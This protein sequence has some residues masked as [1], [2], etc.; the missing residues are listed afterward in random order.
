MRSIGLPLLPFLLAVSLGLARSAAAQGFDLVDSIVLSGR[1]R[2]IY[3]AAVVVIGRRD[4]V[5]YAKGYGHFT[6]DRRAP[7]PDPA[8][9]L[10]DLASLSKV[11]GTTPAVMLLVERGLVDLDAPVQRYLPGFVGEGKPAVTVRMLLNHTSGLPS[12]IEF[13]RLAPTRDSAITLLYAE[14]LRRGPGESA[15]YSDLN[16][17]LLGLLIEARSGTS[18]DAFVSREVFQPL[19]MT[20]S[21]YRPPAALHDRVVPTGL[22]HGRPIA[23]VVNDQNA[24]R[25]G[26]VAGHAGIFSTGTDLARFAQLWLRQGELPAGGHLVQAATMREFLTPTPTSGVRLLGWESPDR[27]AEPP[28]PYGSLLS[29]RAY[30][31]TG[32]TGT[33]LWIDPTRDLFLVFLTNRCFA[34]RIGHSIRELRAVRDRLSD[35]VVGMADRL[36]SPGLDR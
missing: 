11:V 23:G 6:W 19:G 1:S 7:V 30:G 21:R 14:P 33:L 10:W 25:F 31:H 15:E 26:E 32:W 13:F 8:K 28:T 3:P 22:W 12:Y 29:P 36:T 24:V 20:E 4:T 34:P 9:S 18:L 5:L 17:M 2:G 16:A 35:A 27:Q